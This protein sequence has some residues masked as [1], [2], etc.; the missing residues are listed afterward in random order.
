[1]LG[2]KSKALSLTAA[3]SL[4]LTASAGLGGTALEKTP[5]S[6]NPLGMTAYVD[7]LFGGKAHGWT[8]GKNPTQETLLEDFAWRAQ[9]YDANPDWDGFYTF[10]YMKANSWGTGIDEYV[11]GQDWLQTT[12]QVSIQGGIPYFITDASEGVGALCLPFIAPTDGTYKIFPNAAQPNV[13]VMYPKYFPGGAEYGDGQYV[14]ASSTFQMGFAIHKMGK[15]ADMDTYDP[16][17][18]TRLYPTDKNYEL[19]TKEVTSFAF[20]TLTGIALKA[21][22]RLRFVIDCAGTDGVED[23]LV[24]ASMFPMVKC[25]DNTPPTAGDGSYTCTIGKSVSGTLDGADED[26]DAQLTYT[27]KTDGEKGSAAV[28]ADGSFTY[29]ADVGVEGT[30]RFVYTVTDEN[31]AAADGTVT[32]EFVDNKKPA[33]GQTAFD[34]VEG[35]SLSGNLQLSDADGDSVAAALK[36]DA[37]HGE[38]ALEADGAFVYTPADSY[39][40]PDSFVVTLTDGKSPVDVTVTLT[41]KKYEPPAAAEQTVKTAKGTPVEITLSA[42]SLLDGG[43]TYALKEQPVSGT[44]AL[45]DGKV[46]YTPAEGF[47]GFDTF[48]FTANDGRSDSAPAKVTIAV[49]GEGV[50]STATL[51]D[52]IVECGGDVDKNKV[53]DFSGYAYDLPWRFQYR[54]EGITGDMDGDLKFETAIAATLFDWGGYMLRDGNTYPSNTIQSAGFLGG[55]MVN[56]INSGYIADDRN[57]VAALTFVAPE[58]ATYFITGGEATDR[59][60]IWQGQASA[61]PIQVWIEV[62]GAMVWPA[63]GQ[64]LKLNDDLDAVA[65]PDLHIAMKEGA[66]LRFCAQGT[67]ANVDHNNIYLDPAAYVM[68]PYD[69]ALDPVPDTPVPPDPEGNDSSEPSVPST[70]SSETEAPAPD[71]GSPLP[72]AALLTAAAAGGAVLTLRG[73]KRRPL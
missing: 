64:P 49:L 47:T 39:S 69:K 13:R 7:E 23:W 4:L 60:G 31:G 72:A 45:A 54:A 36:T 11:F 22:E 70:D 6:Q 5:S 12:G 53:F 27:L 25:T 50:G 35:L 43:L 71:T 62:D 28:N 46:T 19:L 18:S 1:M 26:E 42:E 51:M 61:N 24:A 32:I 8:D 20:P 21:G 67:T 57:P 52:A 55:K 15:D 34:T 29:T 48:T 73:R 44:A 9:Y 65:L 17:G 68:G 38:L 66:S 16:A 40:G 33:A 2:F 30:D 37:A 3:A 56:A 59:I 14:P 41:V 10:K 58:D 63:D